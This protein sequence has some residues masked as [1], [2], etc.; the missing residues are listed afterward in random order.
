MPPDCCRLL[1]PGVWWNAASCILKPQ[2]FVPAILTSSSKLCK[3]RPLSHGGFARA[4]RGLGASA[5]QGRCGTRASTRPFLDAPRDSL[6]PDAATLMGCAKGQSSSPT[7][8]Q[9]NGSIQI[10]EACM[11]R[12]PGPLQI[13]NGRTT[14]REDEILTLNLLRCFSQKRCKRCRFNPKPKKNKNLFSQ[15]AENPRARRRVELRLSARP[16]SASSADGRLAPRQTGP[17]FLPL[18]SRE[19]RNGV[20]L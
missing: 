3:S 6:P 17:V 13:K 7:A 9:V 19:W 4:A 11:Y 14:C 16:S 12:S 20:Q 15:L 2:I 18:V 10:V 1:F 5:M 8:S